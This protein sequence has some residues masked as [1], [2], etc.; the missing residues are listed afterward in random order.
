MSYPET[1]PRVFETG[2]QAILG[3]RGE[4]AVRRGAG[5]ILL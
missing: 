2:G 1:L 3:V 5:R 4:D